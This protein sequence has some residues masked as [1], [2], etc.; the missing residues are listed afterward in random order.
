MKRRASAWE[1]EALKEAASQET[2]SEVE[3]LGASAPCA[4]GVKIEP[5]LTLGPSVFLQGP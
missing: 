4:A 5:P 2:C 3:E 1:W